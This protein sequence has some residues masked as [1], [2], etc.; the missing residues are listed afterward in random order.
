M[1]LRVARLC[2]DCEEVFTGEVC[3]ICASERSAF[4]S[5]WLPVE[6]RRRWRRS[7]SGAGPATP[8][9]RRLEAIRQF[10]RLILGE[11]EQR[12]TPGPPRTRR[13]DRLPPMD[14]ED[15]PKPSADAQAARD[16]ARSE[17]T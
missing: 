3:P 9:A 5:A 8:R 1:Q 4:L 14:F 10:F 13:S 17:V 2:L 12:S 7:T 15:R 6:E 11:P 16:R